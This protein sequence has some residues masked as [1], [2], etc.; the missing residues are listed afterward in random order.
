MDRGIAVT[1]L[2]EVVELCPD[3]NDK[4]IQLPPASAEGIKE[5]YITT[6]PDI[7][8]IK[9][10]RNLAHNYNLTVK[11]ERNKILITENTNPN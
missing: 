9:C 7:Q 6:I 4:N 8:S 1:F 2:K 3:V 10:I 11:Q 5:I